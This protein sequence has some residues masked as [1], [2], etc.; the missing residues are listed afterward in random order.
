MCKLIINGSLQG[1]LVIFYI[2]LVMLTRH[3][4]DGE[5]S[6][7]SICIWKLKLLQIKTRKREKK[8]RPYIRSFGIISKILDV[9]DHIRGADTC[10]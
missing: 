8:E 5:N 3:R 4:K 1:V 10:I 9:L 6:L 7:V 2:E